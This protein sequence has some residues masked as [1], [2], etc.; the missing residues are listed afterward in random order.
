MSEIYVK[1]I[2]LHMWGRAQTFTG[3]DGCKIIHKI[4]IFVMS[5]K[6]NETS[7][8]K[9]ALLTAS[10]FELNSYGFPL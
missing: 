10:K 5:V 3:M 4:I 6:W 2:Y 1:D 9:H 8:F 7:H